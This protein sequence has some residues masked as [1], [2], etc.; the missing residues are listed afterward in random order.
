MSDRRVAIAFAERSRADGRSLETQEEV[1]YA[2]TNPGSGGRAISRHIAYTI[3]AENSTAMTGEGKAD[4][5]FETDRA[6]S[7]D[8][9][10]GYATNQGGNV[11]QDHWDVRR[12]TPT[13][14]ER[15]QGFP[16]GWTDVDGMSDSARYKMLG[17]AMCVPVAEWIGRRIMEVD[18]KWRD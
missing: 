5:A 4:V 17:N 9:C 16:D 14:C 13:E 1:A 6:R 18:G 3:H 10:G 8:S 2:L 15:L 7:L 11:V 12:L